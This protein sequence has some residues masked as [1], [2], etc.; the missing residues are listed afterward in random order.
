[1]NK[2]VAL[3]SSFCDSEEKLNVLKENIKKIKSFLDIILISPINLPNDIVKA[4]D[5]VF[6]TKDNPVIEWP[7]KTQLYYFQPN[8]QDKT[9]LYTVNKDY[10]WAGLSQVKKLTEIA[11]TF[12]YEYFYHMIYDLEIDDNVI[13]IFKGQKENWIGSFRRAEVKTES[14]L[15]LMVFNVENVKKLKNLITLESYL[16]FLNLNSD[17]DASTEAFVETVRRDLK[18]EKSDF[19]IKD[20]IHITN[21]V[22]NHSEVDD[23]PFFI[24]KNS[25][26]EAP[27]IRIFFYENKNIPNIKIIINGKI[28]EVDISKSSIFSSGVSVFELESAYILLSDKK[29]EILNLI[30]SIKYSEIKIEETA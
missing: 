8:R 10:G 13:N 15:H 26:N 20:K 23:L 3:I 6:Y 5:Y 24:E 25:K 7:L 29:I 11:L 27:E 17:A 4:C 14:S 21:I 16:D 12:S 18:S 30:K 9:V 22:F 2:K 1:M 19:F 28:S